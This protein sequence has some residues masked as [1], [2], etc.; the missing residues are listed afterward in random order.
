MTVISFYAYRLYGGPGVP[1]NRR[2][3]VRMTANWS[4]AHNNFHHK[5]TYVKK[6]KLKMAH[7]LNCN[8]SF[9]PRVEPCGCKSVQGSTSCSDSFHLSPHSIPPQ[10]KN[11]KPVVVELAATKATKTLKL[12]ILFP[13]DAQ[14]TPGIFRDVEVSINEVKNAL[15]LT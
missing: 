6:E 14:D 8:C 12:R 13:T 11:L 5:G 9:D 15:K 7:C 10:A 4:P 1:D 2:L 3:A